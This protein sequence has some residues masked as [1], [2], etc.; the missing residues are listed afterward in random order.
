MK[1]REAK[2][3]DKNEAVYSYRITCVHAY[4][5][6]QLH[7]N[8]IIFPLY[9]LSLSLFSRPWV[10]IKYVRLMSHPTSRSTR[11]IN[12]PLRCGLTAG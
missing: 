2:K 3:H 11:P 9:Y 10:L 6:I 5:N 12:P 1:L 7:S 4:T 8:N